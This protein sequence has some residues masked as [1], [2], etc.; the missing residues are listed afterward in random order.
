MSRNSKDSLSWPPEAARDPGPGVRPFAQPGSNLVLDFHGDPESAGLAVFSD[1]N[2]HMA[3]EAVTRRF[4]E[5][6]PDVGDVFYT[7]TPPAPLVDALKGDGLAIGNLRITR[8]PDAFI[9]PGNILDGLVEAGF[10]E[11]HA[12][13]AE[14]R[15][16]VFLVRKGNP[17]GIRE[18]A[19]L[20]APGVR[21][22]VS[23]PE[24][25]KASYVVYRDTVLGLAD[26]S[27]ADRAALES[28]LAAASPGTVFSSTIHHREVPEFLAADEADVA[29]IYYHLALRYTRIFPD[30]FELVALG[31]TPEGPR[32][33]ANL[34]TRYHVGLVG[35][36]GEW[37]ER[38]VSFLRGEQARVLYEEHGLQRSS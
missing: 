8:K 2:H 18:I 33:P 29:V 5:E 4:V 19:D 21:L 24:S 25:E 7:T 20:L 27:G 23:N 1:G 38:F 3:L 26:E 16:N 12:A 11:N 37:G 28:V 17:K 35:E 22:A 14:S 10:M 9:G 15:G 36:G 30:T 13:F 6:H 32:S 31:G 34:T